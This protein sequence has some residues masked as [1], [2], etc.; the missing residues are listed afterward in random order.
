MN[1]LTV[2][3]AALLL[4]CASLARAGS[5]PV[6]IE[7][8]WNEKTVSYTTT[9]VTA[10]TFDPGGF[11]A[12][13]FAIIGGKYI[14]NGVDGTTAGASV[15]ITTAT[16]NIIASD[17]W[18]NATGSTASLQIAQ[19]VKTPPP[20]GSNVKTTSGFN[21]NA[22]TVNFFSA[23]VISTSSAIIFPTG[24]TIQ[25]FRAQVAN[26]VYILSGLMPSAT[27]TLTLNYLVPA[28]Q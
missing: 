25:S 18:F 4:A 6:T 19:T 24:T 1:R 8:K 11:G 12:S 26:P 23:P 27:Y 7:T 16:K 21:T 3:L 20:A 2:T 10:A 17:Y 5:D 28:A 22:P 13:G 9:S 15:T 14:T